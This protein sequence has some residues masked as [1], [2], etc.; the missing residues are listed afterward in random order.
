MA[1]ADLGRIAGALRGPADRFDA[2]L[3]DRFRRDRDEGAF[4]ELVRR[5]GR[6]VLAACRHVL[7]DPGAVDD[8]FQATFV[9]LLRR[10]AVVEAATVGSWLYAVAQPPNAGAKAPCGVDGAA[11]DLEKVQGR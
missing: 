10:I 2:E 1:N 3:L 4:A 7:A 8:S 5:H 9:V 6:T 11:T